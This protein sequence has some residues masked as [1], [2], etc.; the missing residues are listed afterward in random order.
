MSEQG[1]HLWARAGVTETGL[2][3]SSQWGAGDLRTGKS[4]VGIL[5]WACLGQKK[6]SI[7]KAQHETYEIEQIVFRNKERNSAER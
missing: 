5:S 1:P 7:P 3:H 6:K 2:S 4:N